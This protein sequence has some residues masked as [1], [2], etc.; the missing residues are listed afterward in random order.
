MRQRWGL[1]TAALGFLLA[2]VSVPPISAAEFTSC[3]DVREYFKTPLPENAYARVQD[4]GK[5]VEVLKREIASPS[6]NC[7]DWVIERGLFENAVALD[8]YSNTFP[9]DAQA[10]RR[11]ASEA[12]QGF[13]TYLDWFLG[14]DRSKQDEL[15]RTLTRTRQALA[16]EFRN[17]RRRWLRSRV[18]NVLNSMGAAFA[19]AE[20]YSEM[21]GVYEELFRENIEIFPN[22]VAKKWHK[23]LRTLPDFSRL[24]EDREIKNLIAQDSEHAS[25]WGA[26]KDFLDAFIPGNPSVQGEWIPVREKIVRWL[27]R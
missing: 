14:L 27:A 26:F 23:L 10:G 4:L 3:E 17:T 20:S 18:G 15:I 2:G 24:K 6:D 9:S 12:T 25:R 7:E 1:L 13:R 11:W 5:A 21:F 8:G 16:A 22:E 19:R